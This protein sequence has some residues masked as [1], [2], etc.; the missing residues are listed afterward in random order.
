MERRSTIL[1][2]NHYVLLVFAVVSFLI[3]FSSINSSFHLD[4]FNN[5]KRNPAVHVT[6]ISLSTLKE[7]AFTEITA[8]FR[9]IPYLSFALNHY[10]SGLDTTSYHAVNIIIHALNA[11]L[12]YLIILALF[13][14][15]TADDEKKGRLIISA[16]FTALFWL[17]TPS[18]SQTVIY[19]VQRMTLMMTLFFLLSFLF[20]ILGRK[21]KNTKLIILSGTFFLLSFL[22][23][24]NALAFPLVIILYELIFERK[25]DFKS[26]S[27]KEKIS[28]IIITI[29]LFLPLII[30][31]EVIYNTYIAGTKSWGFTYYERELTQFRVLVLY[32]SLMI[33]PLPGRL[34]LMHDIQKSTSP[35]SPVTTIFS[36]ILILGLFAVSIL[37]IK[38]SPYLSF[39]LLWYFITMSVEAIVP[40]E[41][42]Y[43][44]RMYLPCIFL[45]GAA[46]NYLTDRFYG[47]NRQ[48]LISAFCVIIITLGVLTSIRGKV[49]KDE[50]TLWEDVAKKSPHSSVALTKVG[51]HHY[52]K[53]D[54]VKAEKYLLRA[55][56]ER[57]YGGMDI[58]AYLY[59]GNTYYHTGDFLKAIEMYKKV[60]EYDIK[61]DPSDSINLDYN[62]VHQSL[63]NA[64]VSLG[65]LDNALKNY[66]KALHFGLEK[67]ST[68]NIGKIYN[69][70][71]TIY[72]NLKKYKEAS[73]NLKKALQ[74][75][76]DNKTIQKNILDVDILL[77]E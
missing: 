1:I 15:G 76:P 58:Y 74:Y 66:E 26:I 23:K 55:L 40:V 43:E 3:Y 60:L 29:T 6:D 19:I 68:K 9:P 71:G 72:L 4:D 35:F 59:L 69:N 52:L 33:L 44:H 12:I 48:V 42:M 64:Y 2:R 75:L 11:F 28:L 70:I 53:K 24:Q 34:N 65:D 50:I 63:A 31:W 20:Y 30:F 16:F 73:L 38:K 17:V 39:A 62:E 10:F 67:D 51:N 49:W 5:I 8:G 21:R 25:G 32:L 37:R 41:L 54:Y 47:K 27:K 45:I 36:I 56:E 7:A 14:Y 13:D 61:D 57:K 18:N 46:V 22:S 77:N